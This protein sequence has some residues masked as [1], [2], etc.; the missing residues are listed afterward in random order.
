M[1]QGLDPQAVADQLAGWMDGQIGTEMRIGE[2]LIAVRVRAPA[3]LRQRVEQIGD[4]MLR[5]PDGHRV[6]VRQVASVAI[7]AG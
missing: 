5:A 4:F 7:A 3:D 2:Q 1:Q 6:S